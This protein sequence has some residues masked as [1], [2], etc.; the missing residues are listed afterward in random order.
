MTAPE[1]WTPATTGD[2]GP[3]DMADL[4]RSWWPRFEGDTEELDD[5]TEALADQLLAQKGDT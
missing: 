1:H 3:D 5:D 4:A 2:I